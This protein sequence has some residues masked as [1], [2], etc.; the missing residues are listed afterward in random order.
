MTKKKII[1]FSF[2]AI[3]CGISAVLCV[4]KKITAAFA[5]FLRGEPQRLKNHIV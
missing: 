1:A 2:S 5:A 3:L 4:K